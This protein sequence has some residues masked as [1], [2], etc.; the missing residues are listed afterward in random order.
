M[1]VDDH[2]ALAL[3]QAEDL[4]GKAEVFVPVAADADPP[5]EGQ[6]TGSLDPVTQQQQLSRNINTNEEL[7]NAH[8]HAVL[9]DGT[10]NSIESSP[11]P[12]PDNA[13]MNDTDELLQPPRPTT[14][15][16]EA[17]TPDTD[18]EMAPSQHLHPRSSRTNYARDI[19]RPQMSLREDSPSRAVRS[20]PADDG[21]RLLRLRIHQIRELQ[22]SA[23]EKARLMHE[24]MTEE[25]H[26]AQMAMRP[27]SPAS[28]ISHDGRERERTT[29]VPS[30]PISA[31]TMPTSPE[32]V[33]SVAVQ[34][35]AVDPTNPYNVQPEDLQVS[36]RPL[37]EPSSDNSHPSEDLPHD[38][39]PSTPEPVLGC[40]HYKRNVKIQC[41]DCREWHSCR[42]CH[43]ANVTTH[44]LNRRA[45][46]NMLCMLCW[47]PQPAGQY[48]INKDCGVQAAWYYCDICKLWDDDSSKSIYHCPDCGICRR[49]EGLGKDFVHCKVCYAHCPLE[50]PPES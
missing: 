45:T 17:T 43:D 4:R 16:Q 30:S 37:P 15:T 39:P 19:P 32:S 7:G 47:T 20:L 5:T 49:G 33:A 11:A 22:T 23:E 38:S 48:C 6:A 46:E 21:M 2:D 12:T 41:H 29:F 10:V 9:F 26:R 27:Q 42:H 25:W 3:P 18:A 44:H 40:K 35:P 1:I 31:I 36:Y 8:V 28:M 50:S 24:L 13:P 14:P 34:R